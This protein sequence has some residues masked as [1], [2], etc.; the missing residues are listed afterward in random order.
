MEIDERRPVVPITWE[1]NLRS[2]HCPAINHVNRRNLLNSVPTVRTR[3]L[4]GLEIQ[5][6]NVPTLPMTS[7]ATLM[8]Q[9]DD[10][11]AVLVAALL[12]TPEATSRRR[13]AS[14]GSNHEEK[15]RENS[16]ESNK[17]GR[18]NMMSSTH[19]GKRK[20]DKVVNVLGKGNALWDSGS[21]YNVQ[22]LAK[23][24][25]GKAIPADPDAYNIYTANGDRLAVSH[26]SIIDSIDESVVCNTD[27]RIISPVQ[28]MRTG[29]S[30]VE[31]G[32]KIKITSKTGAVATVKLTD[33]NEFVI[34][35][36]EVDKLLVS[37]TD[38]LYSLTDDSSMDDE[39]DEVTSEVGELAEPVKDAEEEDVIREEDLDPAV[40]QRVDKSYSKQQRKRADKVN[41]L[42]MYAYMSNHTLTRALD[43]GCIAGTTLTG[44]DV[45]TYEAIY[46][47]CLH[48]IAGKITAPSYRKPSEAAP[49][50]RAGQVL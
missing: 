29:H 39:D 23:N 20:S 3:P 24:L 17:K 40:M 37:H 8:Q 21:T 6:C 19:L 38:R 26:Y 11:N 22:Q 48:C 16:S 28:L 15:Y 25:P 35:K 45:D 41:D 42:H 50:V 30:F 27:C 4:Q 13:P 44:A 36:A 9:V 46:G 32:T 2:L 43:T 7:E 31:E 18:N 14:E 5:N 49:A 1:D 10:A 33:A 34:S 12:A 47:P